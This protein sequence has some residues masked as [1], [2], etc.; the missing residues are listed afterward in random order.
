MSSQRVIRLFI[1]STFRDMIQERDLLAKRVHP[2]LRK[3][4]AD[5]GVHFIDVDLRWGITEEESKEGNAVRLCLAEIERC[6]PYFIGLLGERYGW[7]PQ[8]TSPRERE[9][10]GVVGGYPG[11]S[12]TAME[13][14]HGVLEQ[15][16]M[17]GLAHFYLRDEAYIEKLPEGERAEYRSKDPTHAQRLRELKERILASGHVTR[18]YP[19]PE[20]LVDLVL[21]DLEALIEKQFP[22]AE[23]PSALEQERL[24]HEAVAARLQQAY[25]P[26]PAPAKALTAAVEAGTPLVVVTGEPGHGKSALLA[27]WT[28]TYR[29]AHPETFVLLH[30]AGTTTGSATWQGI[31]R[32]V[33]GELSEHFDLNLSIPDDPGE[34]RV[35][36]ANSLHIA[37]TQARILL[38]LDGLNQ[39]AADARELYWM[40]PSLPEGVQLVTSSIGGPVL[41]ALQARQASLVTVGGVTQAERRDLIER[42]LKPYGRRLEPALVEEQ[43]RL[44]REMGDQAGL[45]R[46][47]GNQGVILQS[48]GRLDEAMALQKE[49]ERLC[50]ELQDASGLAMTLVNQA[51]IRRRQGSKPEGR[52]LVQRALRI[53]TDSGLIALSQRIQR[54]LDQVY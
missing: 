2:Q 8:Q 19:N 46:S 5:R 37:A 1:S 54:I 17:Q 43:E 34:L 48:W 49:A 20:A 24:D 39:L 18:T 3:F 41:E 31:C 21:Q 11:A 4:C 23:R 53:A 27:N 47:L 32:R 29:G 16:G 44:C 35:A 7:V 40:P 38:V 28:A 26:R 10:F 22:L 50:R 42:H 33:M 15:E 25:A 45:Y 6:R 30:F 9:A 13:I 14:I 36:F 12:V 51:A 52:V